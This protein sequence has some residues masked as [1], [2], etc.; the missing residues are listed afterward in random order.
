MPPPEGGS[1]RRS[2]VP[3]LRHLDR[4]VGLDHLEDVGLAG[5]SVAVLD[6]SQRVELDVVPVGGVRGGAVPL[7]EDHEPKHHPD[8]SAAAV[9]HHVQ[10]RAGSGRTSPA[11][12]RHRA[13]SSRPPPRRSPRTTF[14]SHH[15]GRRPGLEGRHSLRHRSSTDLKNLRSAGVNVASYLGAGEP[16]A[17]SS[18]SASRSRRASDPLSA[19]PRNVFRR[20]E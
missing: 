2:D 16:L 12:P 9:E 19:S 10:S 13:E 15:P 14:P 17:N 8:R 20:S 7:V 18:A 6:P 11:P 1:R 4:A 3:R 5:P